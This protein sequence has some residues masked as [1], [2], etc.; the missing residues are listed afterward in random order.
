MGGS[1]GTKGLA[2]G[3]VGGAWRLSVPA[4]PE[5]AYVLGTAAS[6]DDAVERA[7]AEQV[8]NGVHPL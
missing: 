7:A 4:P 6:L 3:E 8:E 1:T 5:V 2:K